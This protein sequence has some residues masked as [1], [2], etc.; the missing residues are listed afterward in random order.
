VEAAE[1]ADSSISF[2]KVFEVFSNFSSMLDGDRQHIEEQDTTEW[3]PIN[4][5]DTKAFI[6]SI[7]KEVRPVNNEVIN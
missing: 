3:Q 4:I 7:R 5:V 6:A 2:K 1:E